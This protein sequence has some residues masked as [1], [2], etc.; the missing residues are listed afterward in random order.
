[1]EV[2]ESDLACQAQR[3]KTEIQESVLVKQ[4]FLH[5][6]SDVLAR[7]G[8]LMTTAFQ[9]GHK[10]LSCGNGG[11]ACDAQ[12][13]SSECLNR[14]ERER[15]PLPAMALSCDTATLTSIGN[16]YQFTDI[17]AKQIRALGQRNDLLLA[18]STS[19]QSPNVCAAVEAAHA[20]QM[21][22]I[23]LTGKDGGSLA[24]LLGQDDVEIR[25]PSS[26]TA[27][28]QECH[29]LSIHC[30]CDCVDEQLFGNKG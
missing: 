2:V 4:A 23:A 21:K 3:I 13:F 18:I 15:I 7:A 8:L 17:F 6:C 30:L 27:R 26:R 24:G 20:R 1:M 29:L 5:E 16:D 19:G 12:H 10:V 25:V 28:I 14:F 22:V 11:S 9:S